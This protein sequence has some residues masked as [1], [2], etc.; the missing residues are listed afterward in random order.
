MDKRIPFRTFQLIVHSASGRH[1]TPQGRADADVQIRLWRD[2]YLSAGDKTRQWSLIPFGQNGM[3]RIKNA[4]HDRCVALTQ[5]K[6][7]AE[8]VYSKTS[9]DESQMWQIRIPDPAQ[10]DFVIASS[11]DPNLVISPKEGSHDG[12]TP[13]E[14]EEFGPWSDQFWRLREARSN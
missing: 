11:I 8:L 4:A 13:L 9:N 12:E 3:V 10:A 14:L 6:A 5:D 1:L 2:G 7:G